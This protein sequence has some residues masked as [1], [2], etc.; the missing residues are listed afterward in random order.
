MN[1]VLPISAL[2]VKEMYRRKDFYVVFVLTAV[3]TVLMGSVS[4]FN[5]A[6]M[7]RYLKELC[8]FLVWVSLLFISVGA[9]ARQL[10]AE[11]EQ[12]TI[13]P[14]LAKP[15][16]RWQLIFGKFLGCWWSAGLALLVFYVFF[17]VLSGTREHH[18]PL[19]S[20]LQAATL[21]WV[22]LGVVIAL[23]MLGSLVF[24]APS[25]NATICVVVIVG[26]LFLARYLNRIAL[27][28]PEPLSSL[29][30]ALYF[31]LPH[32]EFFDVRD[33]V[34][35]NRPPVPWWAWGVASAYG[36]AYIAFF[37]GAAWLAFRKKRLST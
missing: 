7:A 18:W 30:Y 1:V 14:L 2:V 27:Q 19:G 15:V 20:Y 28:Q 4:F 13:F 25:S 22:L 12:R 17:A 8:L 5:D 9:A 33:L 35:H 31:I 3:I 10:P 29:L 36:L 6:S 23:V 21:H 16:S 37:L 32:L 26:M 24:T 34:I 11:R